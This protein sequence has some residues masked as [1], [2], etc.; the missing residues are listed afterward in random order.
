MRLLFHTLD[1]QHSDGTAPPGLAA[2]P[3][4]RLELP[5]RALA[6]LGGHTAT[7]VESARLAGQV[8]ICDL[9]DTP[10]VPA[11]H[12]YYDL[13][14]QVRP[15][16]RAMAMACDALTVSSA[17]LREYLGTLPGCPPVHLLRNAIDP[18]AW[19]SP[20]PIREEPVLGWC[21]S[22][23]E[24]ADDFTVLRPWLGEFLERHDLRFIHV[25]DGPIG[26]PG[27]VDQ[28]VSFAE[29]AQIDPARVERRPLRSFAEYLATRPWS[30]ID[31]ALVPLMDH[32]YSRGKSCLKGLESAVQG[33][34]FVAS[35]HD[36]YKWLGCGR[37]AGTEMDHQSPMVWEAALE[38][39]LDPAERI[40]S[41]AEAYER[42]TREDIRVR[43][44]EW[45]RV[46]A[47]SFPT[48]ATHDDRHEVESLEPGRA[49]DI[50]HVGL[51]RHRRGVLDRGGWVGD[52]LGGRADGAPSTAV[53]DR[54]G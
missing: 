11:T 52:R 29:A 4:Y 28:P 41:A 25:G 18:E 21:G 39:M 20:G 5:R 45:E 2:P 31:I 54:P 1:F 26:V 42:A 22:V 32:H 17:Y 44:R 30:G 34:P 40:G 36:E 50:G 7:L 27:R 47:R 19:G 35:P 14:E 46:Y 23:L 51:S 6:G 48:A 15:L 37:L 12:V 33:I 53:D 24:R 38:A 8:V 13:V 49:L 43:W 3:Y 16:A 10:E 9:T